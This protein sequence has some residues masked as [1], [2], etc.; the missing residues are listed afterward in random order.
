MSWPI[1][2]G[3]DLVYVAWMLQ[4][5]S[6]C[7]DTIS[8]LLTPARPSSS[9]VT[10]SGAHSSCSGECVA[11]PILQI[12]CKLQQLHE[13]LELDDMEDMGVRWVALPDSGQQ[14]HHLGAFHR[15]ARGVGL[16]TD[17]ARKTFMQDS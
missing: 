9:P 12:Y 7:P 6:T 17:V 14:V 5:E 2:A 3:Y 4:A 15:E 10:L 1:Q 8:M 11:P 13:L 16:G